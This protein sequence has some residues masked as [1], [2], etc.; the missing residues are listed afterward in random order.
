MGWLGLAMYAQS[1]GGGGGEGG[2]GWTAHPLISHAPLPALALYMFAYSA[3]AGPLQW[4]WLGELVPPE[5]KFFSGIIYAQG[6]YFF[7]AKHK[8][9]IYSTPLC[10]SPR[11]NWDFPNPSPP[12]EHALPP[13]PKG[14]GAHSPASKGMGESQFRRLE[15]KLST[16]PTLCSEG[17][18]KGDCKCRIC[19]FQR[20]GWMV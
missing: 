12:S 8:V 10:M 4:V 13:G 19:S 20:K 5:Y 6:A 16:L 1:L 18:K 14:G 11:R 3:G 7:T 2:E 15:K 17:T 9:L